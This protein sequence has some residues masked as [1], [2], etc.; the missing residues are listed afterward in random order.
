MKQTNSVTAGFGISRDPLPHGR[1]LFLQTIKHLFGQNS[2]ATHNSS[3]N[4]VFQ[5]RQ[6]LDLSFLLLVQDGSP[7]RMIDQLDNALPAILTVVPF[8]HRIAAIT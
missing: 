2:L 1:V 3:A 6:H 4:R 5:F 7:K 8:V